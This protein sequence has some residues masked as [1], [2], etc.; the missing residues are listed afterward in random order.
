[1]IPMFRTLASSVAVAVA[2]T[3]DDPRS[4]LVVCCP[5]PAVVGECLVG[6]GHLVHVL[7]ALDARAEPVA[8]VKQLVLQSPGHRLLAAAPGIRNQPA[9][10]EGGAAGRAD[11]DRNLVGRAADPPPPEL[12]RPLHA[13]QA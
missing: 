5:L 12:Q 1:M 9:Q 13:L 4:L 8:G 2:A 11:L 10:G 6:P 3:V 7:A